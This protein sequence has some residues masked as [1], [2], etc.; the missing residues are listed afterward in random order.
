MTFRVS[1]AINCRGAQAEVDNLRRGPIEKTD[2]YSQFGNF[3]KK[4]ACF[5]ILVLSMF[6]N[7]CQDLRGERLGVAGISSWSEGRAVLAFQ[8][9]EPQTSIFLGAHEVV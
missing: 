3:R 6:Q 1:T 5:L 2:L 9:T 8:F 4:I 7:K